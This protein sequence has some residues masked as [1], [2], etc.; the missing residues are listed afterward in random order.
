MYKVYVNGEVLYDSLPIME[1]DLRIYSPVLTLN[2]EGGI[3]EF[4]LPKGHPLWSVKSSRHPGFIPIK[5]RSD[6]C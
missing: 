1:D 3:F 6:C 4:T 2:K 5:N